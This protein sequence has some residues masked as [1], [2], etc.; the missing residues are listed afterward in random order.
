MKALVVALAAILVPVAAQAATH[1]GHHVSH[2]ARSAY[3][4]QP[5]IACTEVG[6]IP[7]RPG[8]Y[9][10]GGKTWSGNPSGF[11]VMVCPQQGTT[12]Y[13]HL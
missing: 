6:C 10:T 4:A 11:D 9:P 12:L 13:G 1:H 8:C 7:V 3:A 5:Q 2:A